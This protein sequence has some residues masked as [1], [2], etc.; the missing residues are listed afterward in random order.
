MTEKLFTIDFPK[1]FGTP[2]ASAIFRQEPED[3]QVDE[4][5]GFTP[6]GEGEHVYLHV[7]KRG[8]N[9]AWVAE[10][11]ALLANVKPMDVSYCGRKDRQA[12]T[13]QWFSVYL[14]PKRDLLMPD[15]A[16]LNSSSIRVMAVS[17][18]THKLRRGEHSS[19]YFVIRLRQIQTEDVQA[20]EQRI[21]RVFAQGVPNYFGE[22]R[23]GREGNNLR[24]AEAFLVGGK[25]Y[26]DRQKQG[27][28]LSSARSYL[29][30][31]VLAKRVSMGNWNQ[32]IDGEP[33]AK[34]SGPLWGRGRSLALSELLI[35]ESDVLSQWQDWCNA[36][37][38][39]GL[40]QERRFL[41]LEINSGSFRWL[42]NRDLEI[43][44]RLEAGA[45][46]TSVM[47]ELFN[48][49]N[50]SSADSISLE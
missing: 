35:L 27:L 28:I 38:H 22:Q 13:M 7:Y 43:S 1:A 36:L 23:F 48:L 9:T 41:N 12:V 42:D 29:F 11:I 4:D 10:Q 45:F 3:F 8:E 15:W 46:A 19:N 17:R 31:L 34:P 47:A 49:G 2:E 37:E 50:Q 24:E 26:R 14:P 44:F 21:A 30:N 20:L 25:R 5:L 16:L 18:H 6:C 40:N 33:L 39:K 32:L